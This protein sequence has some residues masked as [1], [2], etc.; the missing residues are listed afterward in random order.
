M[1]QTFNLFYKQFIL[2]KK[3]EVGNINFPKHV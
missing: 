1:F 3:I 2:H